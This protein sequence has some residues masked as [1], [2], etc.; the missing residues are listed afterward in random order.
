MKLKMPLWTP[1]FDNSVIFRGKL[2][3]WFSTHIRV[4]YRG[5]RADI[6]VVELDPP[7]S[8]P[9]IPTEASKNRRINEISS[10][11]KR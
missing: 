1:D 4:I 10:G 11:T 2:E 3:G 8:D 6:D 5:T 9:I 7:G